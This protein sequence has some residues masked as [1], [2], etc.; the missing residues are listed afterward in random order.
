MKTNINQVFLQTLY[1]L[2]SSLKGPKN[3]LQTYKRVA[4][5]PKM[6]Y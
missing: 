6:M 1:G 3:M 5:G 2:V 4:G